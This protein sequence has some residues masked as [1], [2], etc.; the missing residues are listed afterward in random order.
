MGPGET[1]WAIAKKFNVE[2]ASLMAW[3][4]M[5]TPNALQAGSQLT[6]RKD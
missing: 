5:K 4:N 2:P 1:V 6:I 3:N